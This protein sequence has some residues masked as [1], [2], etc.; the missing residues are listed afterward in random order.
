M[1]SISNKDC[2][3]A[4]DDKIYSQK[5][6]KKMIKPVVASSDQPLNGKLKL[7]RVVSLPTKYRGPH[8]RR[9][10]MKTRSDITEIKKSRSR[11]VSFSTLAPEE[12]IDMTETKED[13]GSEGEDCGT[14]LLD[15]KH[16]EEGDDIRNLVSEYKLK[17]GL[18]RRRSLESLDIRPPT[19]PNTSHFLKSMSAENETAATGGDEPL[20]E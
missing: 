13:S 20:G 6:D 17:L 18:N 5:E 19:P 3:L 16:E 2:E 9:S 1:S 10:I 8:A 11:Y 14:S 7:T 12:I 15:T 4:T